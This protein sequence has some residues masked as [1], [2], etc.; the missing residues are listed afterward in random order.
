LSSLTDALAEVANEAGAEVASGE[1]KRD[2]RV[3][4]AASGNVAEFQLDPEI[5]EAALGTPATTTSTR[6]G[7][8][9]RLT[10]DLSKPH[11]L[12]RVRAWFLSAWRYAERG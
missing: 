10:V 11:D 1:F 2:G 5:A 6:G 3:F 9:I 12:D 7:D 8:W 4:A